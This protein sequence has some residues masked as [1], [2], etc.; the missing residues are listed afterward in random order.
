MTKFREYI[1][2]IEIKLINKRVI[3]VQ[4]DNSTQIIIKQLN[5]SI[6]ESL[7]NTGISYLSEEIKYNNIHELQMK[8][9]K[10]TTEAIIF[11]LINL[12]K[13]NIIK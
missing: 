10:E 12:I 13:R 2:G 1:D 7:K 5:K 3:I 6:C 11:G 8:L 9:S 4:I